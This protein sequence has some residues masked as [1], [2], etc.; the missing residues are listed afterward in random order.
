MHSHVKRTATTHKAQGYYESQISELNTSLDEWEGKM[1]EAE[2]EC[3]ALRDQITECRAAI[4]KLK[5]RGLVNNDIPADLSLKAYREFIRKKVRLSQEF[6]V[7]IEPGE[8]GPY[9]KSHQRAA[10][11][12]L[13]RSASGRRA[14]SLKYSG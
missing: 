11:H 8:I 7:K 10:A 13:S 2:S 3:E 12:C 14:S 5:V 6:G 9:L 4:D 1:E